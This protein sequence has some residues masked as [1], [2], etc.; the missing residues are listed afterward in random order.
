VPSLQ[1]LM[2]QTCKQFIRSLKSS[3]PLR[4]FELPLNALQK[5][6]IIMRVHQC[7]DSDD[8]TSHRQIKIGIVIIAKTVVLVH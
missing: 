6:F 3:I 7:E 5:I 1:L 2:Y 4:N 8:I